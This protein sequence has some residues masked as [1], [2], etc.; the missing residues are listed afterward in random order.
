VRDG[1]IVATPDL[2]LNTACFEPNTLALI[3]SLWPIIRTPCPDQDYL[4]QRG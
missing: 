1:K 3:S 2:G 4:F